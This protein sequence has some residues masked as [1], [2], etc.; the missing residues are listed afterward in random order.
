MLSKI[1]DEDTKKYS[2][3]LIAFEKPLHKQS[4]VRAL[5]RISFYFC[6]YNIF[7]GG[8]SGRLNEVY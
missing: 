2:N 7:F 5:F 3:T 8:L 4:S 1:N 6:V